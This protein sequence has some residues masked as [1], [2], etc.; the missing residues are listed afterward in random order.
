MISNFRDLFSWHMN[1]MSSVNIA[2]KYGNLKLESE[3][4]LQ[5]H[6]VKGPP[7]NKVTERFFDM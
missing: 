6:Q 4:M 7:V 1:D 3:N 2:S 5:Q